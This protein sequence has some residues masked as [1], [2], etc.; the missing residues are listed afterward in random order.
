MFDRNRISI[1]NLL[2]IV[3]RSGNIDNRHQSEHTALEGARIHRKIQ[4]E[5]GSNYQSEVFLKYQTEMN[6]IPFIVDGRADGIITENNKII[7]DEIK[8]STTPFE[9]IKDNILDMYWYQ[10]MCYAFIVA[11]SNNLSEISIQLTYYETTEKKIDKVIRV[12]EYKQL[13][14]FMDELLIEYAKWH[15]FVTEWRITRNNSLKEIEFCFEQYRKGQKELSIA[16]YKSVVASRK[17]YVE[18]PTGVGK[19]LST[20]FPSLK[21]MGNDYGNKIFYLTAKTITRQVALDAIKQFSNQDIKLKTVLI[22]AKD[23]VCLLDKRDCNPEKCK[24]ADGYYDKLNTALYN[25]I[26]ENDIFDKDLIHKYALEYEVCPFELS[27]DVSMFADLVICDYN[28]LFDPRV[29]LKRYFE[30][31]NSDYIFLIDEAHNLVDRSRMM[32]SSEI[33]LQSFI[34]AKTYFNNNK[35]IYKKIESIESYIYEIVDSQTTKEAAYG[36]SFEQLNFI[37]Y[38]LSNLLSKYLI[39]NQKYLDDD[40]PLELYFMVLNYL[41]ISEFFNDDYITCCYIDNNVIIKQFCLHPNKMLAKSLA[42]ARSSVLFSATFSP[43]NYY[44]EILGGCKE[45]LHYLIASP[46]DQENQKIII[47]KKIATTYALRN[48]YSIQLVNTLKSYVTTKKGNYMFFFPSYKYMNDIFEQFKDESFEIIKQTKEMKESEREQFLAKFKEDNEKPII[49]FCVMGGIFSEGIDL[50]GD[51]LIGV[52]IISVGLPM[53][54]FE[55]NLLKD[56]YDK[57]NSSG[58]LYAYQIPGMNKVI[59]S[60]GR[61]IRDHND[62]GSILLIDSRFEK[63]DY[64]SLMPYHWNH[65][66]IASN[67]IQINNELTEFWK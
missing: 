19:T 40:T 23:K 16:V 58:F 8:T 39:E 6:G 50:K 29:Y 63:N 43:I 17:L 26:N 48:Q 4:S 3:K 10:A 22:S 44:K 62:K 49:A 1:R 9:A 55:Q 30:Q 35:K 54:S 7:I 12:Y 41:K 47:H 38:D 32:Y 53:I 60:A 37:L 27:L 15:K 31:K 67:H 20:L 5:A 2:D 13:K 66:L 34:D 46:F 57:S 21:A 45:D 36:L 14:L 33:D 56:Y 28:Y 51:R 61:L 42:I 59:Q 65:R 11:D 52:A 24:Y 25:L 18:A 64:A